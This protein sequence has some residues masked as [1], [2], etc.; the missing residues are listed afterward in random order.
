M[1]L[2]AATDVRGSKI[3]VCCAG[4]LIAYQRDAFDWLQDSGLWDLPG[5]EREPGETALACAL[6]ETA[7]EFGIDVA[8]H[9][10]TYAARYPKFQQGAWTEVA[11]FA[12]EVPR[13]LID[14][15]V[16]G[17]EGQRWE[18]MPI[19]AFAALPDAVPELQGAVR[20]WLER[21]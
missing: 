9:A 14:A 16:F 7:E 12:A 6:R 10:V 15:I 20:A 8:P 13:A 4:R 5:G 2:A 19:A 18:M 3:A 1:D 21:G 17:E 11:F